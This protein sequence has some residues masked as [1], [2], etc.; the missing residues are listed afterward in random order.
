MVNTIKTTCTL[1]CQDACGVEAEV[2]NNRVVRLRGSKVHPYTEGFLC[3]R[4]NRYLDRL[5]SSER[6][7]SP[8]QKTKDGWRKISWD[9]AIDLAASKF[10]AAVDEYG[11]ASILYF[12]SSG[13]FGISNRYNIRLFNKLGGPT[14]ASG[15]LCLTA[16]VAGM[17]Q[18]LGR[19]ICP[20]PSEMVNSQMIV[21]WGRNP[22]AYSVHMVPL[23]KKARENG[24]KIILIDPIRNESAKFCD[25]HYAPKPGGDGY[26]ALAI[27]KYLLEEDKADVEFLKNA[28]LNA[29]A[30][31]RMSQRFSWEQLSVGCGLSEE[32]LREIAMLFSQ[33]HP[34][35]ICM[36]RGPQHY[37][38]GAEITRLILAA[39]ALSG[40]LGVKGGG[41]NYNSDFWGPFDRTLDG[42]EFA[43]S[44]RTAPKAII[45]EAIL[46]M[47]EPPIRA[48][49]IHGGNPVTQCPNSQKVARAFRSIDFVTVV[50]SFL[51]DTAECADLFLPSAMLLETRDIRAAGW[52]PYVGPVVPAVQPPEGVKA[53]WEIVGLLAQRLGIEDPYL[54][55]PIEQFL[56]KAL[57]PIEKY[58]LN[59][60][61]ATN[62]IFRNPESPRTPFEGGVFATPSGKFEF[63][64][65]W[66]PE[67]DSKADDRYPLRLLSLKYQ[68]Y[69]SSQ[70]LESQQTKS[71]A[72]VWL[73]PE[74]ATRFTLKD[75]E[76]GRLLSPSG[77]CEVVFAL[78]EELRKDVCLARSGGWMKKGHGINVLTEDILTNSGECSGYYETRVRPVAQS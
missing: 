11:P 5:Y 65:E 17:I 46:N 19:S 57:A 55:H 54:G 4:L 6:V 77:E 60:K 10:R 40:N 15:S 27:C 49:Y 18:S 30:I 76:K 68:R 64:E 42:G 43:T 69:Q 71:E 9:N 51:T 21:L 37:K 16:G 75:G 52:N 1:D 72:I 14:V 26:L 25:H 38:Q 34:A 56:P 13:S 63:L 66:E 7:T 33:N 41:Y 39:C 73:H 24:A 20:A 47:K 44:H 28:T 78:D 3:I 61:N 48:A 62:E 2:E 22:V 53:D 59:P 45:G 23:I 74:T 70:M 32:T 29:E 58:G 31:E 67:G 8:L 35:T 12:M 36:G 50:D